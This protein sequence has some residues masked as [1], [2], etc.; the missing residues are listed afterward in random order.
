MWSGYLL[1]GITFIYTLQTR[2]WNVPRDKN[3]TDEKSA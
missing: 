2:R 1:F 3:A